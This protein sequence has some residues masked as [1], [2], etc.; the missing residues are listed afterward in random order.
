MAPKADVVLQ[1]PTRFGLGCQLTMPERPL[2]PHP[3]TFGHFGPAA[4][5]DSPIPTPASPREICYTRPAQ[6]LRN[7][8]SESRTSAAVTTLD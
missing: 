3:R 1:R 7:V 6:M 2:G 5:S 4:R 8:Y